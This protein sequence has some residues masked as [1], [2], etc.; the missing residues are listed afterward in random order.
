VVLPQAAINFLEV[1]LQSQ[2]KQKRQK[3]AK[4]AKREYGNNGTC[5]IKKDREM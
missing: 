5:G 2:W 4:K 3:S 1:N